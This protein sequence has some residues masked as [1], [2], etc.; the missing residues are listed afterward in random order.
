MIYIII[1]LFK[2]NI[3][4]NIIFNIV[5]KEE[6]KSKEFCET[7]YYNKVYKDNDY[8]NIIRAKHFFADLAQFWSENDSIRNIGFKSE[9]I[10]IKPE[11][12]TELIFS[13]EILVTIVFKYKSYLL[14]I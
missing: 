4:I 13:E 8:R 11:S 2:N 14:K 9:N 12:I 6:G 3:C 10:L 5:F 7:Q 1:K